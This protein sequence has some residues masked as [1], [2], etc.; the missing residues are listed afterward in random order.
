MSGTANTNHLID[1]T[2]PYLLQHAHNPVAWHPWNEAALAKARAENKPILLSIGY[3]ACHWCHVM[4]HE[5]FEDDATATLMNNLFINI[6]VDRE[7]RPDLD[8]IYQMAHQL[9]T[10]RGGGWPLTM[11]LMPDTLIPFFGGTYFPLSPRYGM[12]AFKEILVRVE[13]YFRLHGDEIDEQNTYLQNAFDRMNPS[14]ADHDI[15]LT[16]APLDSARQQLEHSF[17]PRFGGFSYAPKF[18]HPAHL[19]RL[20]RHWHLSLGQLADHKA[21]DMVTLTLEKMALGGI[22]DQLG[23]GFCRYSVDEKWIIP[24]FEKMLYDNAQL[25]P[26]YIHSWA[27]TQRPLFK[28]IAMET[29]DWVMREMQ[30][31]AGGYYSTLDA[32]SE[33]EEGKFYVWDPAEV[34]KLLTDDEYAAFVRHFGLDRPANFESLWHLHVVT[35]TSTIAH[36]LSLSQDQVIELIDSARAKLLQQR[37]KR[38]WPGR[39]EKI[40]TSWNGLMIKGMAL[41]ARYLEREDMLESAL[42]SYEFI[43]HNM[44]Q[45]GRLLA[46]CKDGKAHLCAYLDDYAFLLD[47]MLELLQSRWQEGVLTFA[48]EVADVLLRHFEDSQHGGFYF[49]ADDHETLIHRPKPFGDD[50]TPAGNGIAARALARL[51]HLTADM[52][53]ISSAERVLKSAWSSIVELPYAHSS[54]LTALEE[55]LF[56]PQMIILRGRNTESMHAWKKRCDSGYTPRR[57]TFAIPADAAHLSGLLAACTVTDNTTAYVCTGTSCS[58]PISDLQELDRLIAKAP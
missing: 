35:D 58:A 42:R 49:T 21:L 8:K 41:A 3:S 25:L 12:P 36:E 31:P 5:S 40:L 48:I 4:A 15:H 13:E 50:A 28:R 24:H 52:R 38:L 2:S 20:L 37:Q 27:G 47:G 10:H 9:I 18:P 46:T 30:S 7:E 33:G 23:G 6:K 55:T 11:F 34:K 29:A 16:A 56:P 14:P 1:E 39:D 32:D 57:M 45:Q 54:L 17:E 44:W 51:G 53:Y 22:Y 26:I 43:R 19:D